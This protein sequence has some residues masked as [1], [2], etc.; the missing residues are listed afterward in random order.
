ML[1]CGYCNNRLSCGGTG[2]NISHI[3]VITDFSFQQAAIP[4][5]V[6]LTY[7]V[8]IKWFVIVLQN[9]ESFPISSNSPFS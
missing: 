7:S 1:H 6:I 9:S 5:I 2:A 3:E 4:F 8:Q